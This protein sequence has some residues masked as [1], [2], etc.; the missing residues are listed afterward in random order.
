MRYRYLFRGPGGGWF[1]GV[2][3][4][5]SGRGVRPTQRKPDPVQDTK[6]VNLLPCL[7]ESAV[8]SYPV[9]DWTK[10]AVFKTLR[11]VHVSLRF[12]AFQRR[13]TKSA[14]IMRSKEENRRRF[15]GTTLFKTRNV[16]LHTLFK[17]EDPENDTLN[18]GT[19]LQRTHMGVSYM[20]LNNPFTPK[21]DQY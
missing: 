18:G 1:E 8:I 20:G 3:N 14:K 19:S 2:L 7:R 17:T 15:A 4:R 21:I 10:Q 11:T 5:N 13:R 12:H 9:Q 16:E 6:N